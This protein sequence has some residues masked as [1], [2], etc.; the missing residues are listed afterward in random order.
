MPTPDLTIVITTRDRPADMVNGAVDSALAQTLPAIEVVVVDDA[1]TEPFRPASSDNRLRLLRTPR[2]AGVCAARNLGVRAA[3]GRWITFLDDDDR[4]LPD[5][6]AAS[7]AAVRASA[8][9]PPIA[10]VS[11]L[12]DVDELGRPIRTLRPATVARGG[13]YSLGRGTAEH[14]PTHNTLVVPTEVLRAVGGWDEALRS[15]EHVDLFLRL[16]AACSIQGLDQVTY[17]RQ[18]HRS[19]RLSQDLPARIDSVQRT[20]AKHQAAFARH[21][22]RHAHYLGAVGLAWLRLGRRGPAVEMSARALR[23]WPWRLSGVAQLLASV[24]GSRI[25][26]LVDR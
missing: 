19:G 13:H 1:S 17:R 7:L 12:E 8:L 9:P 10:V 6:A 20:L 16:N 23:V 11:A 14:L 4:L 24:A 5:M 2:P 25:W 26:R 3:G 21:P 22:R 15:W 18:A